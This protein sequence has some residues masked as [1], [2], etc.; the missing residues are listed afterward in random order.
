M[1]ER[2]RL[3]EFVLALRRVLADAE[4]QLLEAE[5][6]L[7]CLTEAERLPTRKMGRPLVG[8]RAMTPAERKRRQ[9]AK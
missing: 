9:R 5:R 3:S 2:E 8:M 7:P 4:A 1:D 6:I